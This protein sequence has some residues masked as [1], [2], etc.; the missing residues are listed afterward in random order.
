MKHNK[1]K[2][3]GVFALKLDMEKAYDRVEWCFLESMLSHLGFH[4]SFVALIMRCVS[5]VSFCVLLN[6]FPGSSFDPS[7][8][9]HQGDPLSPF[10]FLVCAEALSG[11]LRRAE[12]GNL[13]HGASLCRNSPRVSHLLFADDCIIFGRSNCEE[14]KVVGEIL[15]DYES[16]SGQKVNLTK[17][18]ISF[19]GGVPTLKQQELAQLLMGVKLNGARTTYL[20]I[21]STVGRSKSEVFQ[22]LV[23]RTRKK[24]KDWKRRYLSGA[25]F[26]SYHAFWHRLERFR[27]QGSRPPRPHGAGRALLGEDQRKAPT[28]GA[29]SHLPAQLKRQLRHRRDLLVE[30]IAWKV[31]NGTRIR[32]GMDAWIPDG[33]GGFHA[34]AV[35][36]RFRATRVADLVQEGSSRWDSARLEEMFESKDRWTINSQLRANLNVPDTP[37]WPHGKFN[38]YSVKSGYWLAVNLLRR[39]EPSS[40]ESHSSLW[41]RIWNLNVIPKVKI[42]M[43]KCVVEALPTNM[44]L[45]SIGVDVNS[46]CRKCGLKDEYMEHSL[47]DCGWVKAL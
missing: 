2:T 33:K 16:V 11:L 32:I 23:D 26:G 12:T 20:G 34:A 44:A 43:W 39:N 30:G 22:M 24:L 19:S 15:K 31:G 9:L 14:V 47:R 25:G 4:A 38:S 6:G 21:P 3:R 10:L 37:F 27:R 41:K 28:A 5:T 45:K 35:E 42:F 8:G 46:K 40:S 1:A 7:R 13:L 17:F 29:A 36:E 18:M